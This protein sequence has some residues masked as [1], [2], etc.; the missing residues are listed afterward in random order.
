M[1]TATRRCPFEGH[2]LNRWGNVYQQGS[3][4]GSG[5]KA[6]HGKNS[7]SIGAILAL[8]GLLAFL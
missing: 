7:K 2:F 8:I 1:T 3:A 6:Q 5:A 4:A